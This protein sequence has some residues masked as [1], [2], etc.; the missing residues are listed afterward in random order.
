MCDDAR[1]LISPEV[2]CFP[3]VPVCSRVCDSQ[4]FFVCFSLSL[5]P[6]RALHALRTYC[7][8]QPW[9][10]RLLVDRRLHEAAPPPLLSTAVP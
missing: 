4:P 8:N 10:T 7:T 3:L 2:S 1:S 6:A 9:C 5:F